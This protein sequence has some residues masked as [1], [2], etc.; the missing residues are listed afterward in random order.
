MESE[1]CDHS[2]LIQVSAY[3]FIHVDEILEA[4]KNGMSISIKTKMNQCWQD[5]LDQNGQILNQLQNAT[6][7][8]F[9]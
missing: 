2:K 6:G 7:K 5:Y 8:I 9:E 4:Q 3:R 1:L